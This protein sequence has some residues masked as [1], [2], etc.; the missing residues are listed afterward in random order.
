[1][2]DGREAS[3][4]DEQKGPQGPLLEHPALREALAELVALA[5]LQAEC[6][7]IEFAGPIGPL[8]HDWRRVHRDKKQ[9][10]LRRSPLAWGA[11]RAALAVPSLPPLDWNEGLCQNCRMPVHPA[12]PGSPPSSTEP[13]TAV[14]ADAPSMDSL[15][16]RMAGR[17]FDGTP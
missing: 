2:N 16:M 14:G 13:S 4:Q 17:A 12:S 6:N 9:D 3:S 1:M 5:D 15:A 11:A 10:F 7:A 8:A